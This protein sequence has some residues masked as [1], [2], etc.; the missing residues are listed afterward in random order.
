MRLLNKLLDVSKRA[1]SSDSMHALDHLQTEVDE[2]VI[3]TV[4]RAERSVLGESPQLSFVLA[5]EQARF[6]IAD[7]RAILIGR[8][9]P[10]TAQIGAFYSI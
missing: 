10:K 7:R 4:H 5:I 9:A 1:R 6:A 3:E 2:L 8:K